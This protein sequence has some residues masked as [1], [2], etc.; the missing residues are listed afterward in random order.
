MLNTLETSTKT[1]SIV[2]RVVPC[3]SGFIKQDMTG[4]CSWNTVDSAE[5]LYLYGT[6][7]EFMSNDKHTYFEN[8]GDI[9]EN[10]INSEQGRSLHLLFCKVIQ[11]T[12][13]FEKIT[14]FAQLLS[15]PRFPFNVKIGFSPVS[16]YSVITV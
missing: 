12:T 4:F 1:T 13:T 9:V 14:M 16:F 11:S 7:A 10:Y 3:I 5:H 2:N 6:Y 15:L 8:A